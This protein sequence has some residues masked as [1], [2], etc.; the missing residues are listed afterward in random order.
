MLSR[1]KINLSFLGPVLEFLCIA[2]V[3]L[4]I[5]YN[6]PRGIQALSAARQCSDKFPGGSRILPKPEDQQAFDSCF[7]K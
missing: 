2:L 5:G 1:Y 7:R 3:L 6:V 4:A